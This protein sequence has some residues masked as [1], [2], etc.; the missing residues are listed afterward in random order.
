LATL[1]LRNPR[2]KNFSDLTRSSLT[3]VAQNLYRGFLD[4]DRKSEQTHRL[5][6]LYSIIFGITASIA[7]AG[8]IDLS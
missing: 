6:F 8:N 1:P 4:N 2:R 5:S 7:T 3:F